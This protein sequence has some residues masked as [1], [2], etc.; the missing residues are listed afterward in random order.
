MVIFG[1]IAD[2]SID[3]FSDVAAF[4]A[5]AVFEIADIWRDGEALCG[6]FLFAVFF[7]ERASSSARIMPF[8]IRLA[9]GGFGGFFPGIGSAKL[10][11]FKP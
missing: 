6:D 5:S 11:D 2:F 4:A 3:L 8:L 1:S 7:G 9:G 10:S